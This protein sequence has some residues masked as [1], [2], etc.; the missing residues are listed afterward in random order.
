MMWTKKQKGEI[1]VSSL[2][3]GYQFD[4]DNEPTF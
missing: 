1:L 3:V 4:N 2:N